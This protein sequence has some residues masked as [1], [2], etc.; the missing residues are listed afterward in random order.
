MTQL[1]YHQDPLEGGWV[2]RR[3]GL[4]A[5]V[6]RENPC[7]TGIKPSHPGHNLVTILIE[8]PWLL[9]ICSSFKEPLLTPKEKT[10]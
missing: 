5:V 8:L 9:A 6:K 3:A 10:V 4:V 1:L 7:L 2:G